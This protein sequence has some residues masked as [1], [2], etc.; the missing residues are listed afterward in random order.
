MRRILNV[1][2]F[3]L[4]LDNCPAQEKNYFL[5]N[6]AI[7]E[8]SVLSLPQNAGTRERLFSKLASIC[9][10]CDGVIIDEYSDYYLVTDVFS[11]ESRT[12]GAGYLPVGSFKMKL[13]LRLIYKTGGKTFRELSF[14]KDYILNTESEAA[15]RIVND[16]TFSDAELTDFFKA[17]SLKMKQFYA[18]NCN[19]ILESV[20]KYQSVGEPE[21]AL[22]ICLS[23]PP[24]QPCFEA[25]SGLMKE[26][27]T[28]LCY[29]SDYSIF[30]QAQD[31]VSKGAYEDAFR[32]LDQ[33]SI[34]SQFYPQAQALG[35]QIN[36]FLFSQAELQKKRE[37][38]ESEQILRQTEIEL[39]K[40]KNELQEGINRTNLEIADKKNESDRIVAS[41]ELE[42]R[43][44]LK[45]M[46]LQSA[47][48]RELIKTTGNLLS[49]YLS[50]PEPPQNTNFYIIK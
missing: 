42:N 23:V 27:W 12:S 34:F 28:A 2:L 22:A 46:E 15:D 17:G 43:K 19:S 45:S 7:G 25:V 49:A 20:K 37:L 31:L 6:L 50:K 3:M 11:T 1:F 48:R 26:I 8:S 35:K 44:E 33:I 29:K 41:K 24:D 38:A 5:V 18:S 39:Q 40:K 47:E 4:L 21:N 9:N 30:L 36:D 13:V 32:T 16:F 14:S 10:Q